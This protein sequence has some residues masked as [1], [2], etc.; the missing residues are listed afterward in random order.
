[1]PPVD[2]EFRDHVLGVM[3]G[4]PDV[5]QA[6]RGLKGAFP[7]EYGTIVDYLYVFGPRGPALAER[8]RERC[9]GDALILGRD[10]LAQVS[11]FGGWDHD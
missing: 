3:Q 8:Y 6:L 4:E 7:D 5:E 10:V 9:G 2:P 11:E 1:M